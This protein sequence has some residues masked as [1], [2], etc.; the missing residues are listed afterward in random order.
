MRFRPANIRV[1]NRRESSSLLSALL[2]EKRKRPA[3]LLW[4][5]AGLTSGVNCQRFVQLLTGRSISEDQLAP[6]L[7][8]AR[9]PGRSDLA[10]V[11]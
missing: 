3:L 2:S 10:E 8:H 5:K 7:E 4:R 6:E 1:I 9:I 11:A